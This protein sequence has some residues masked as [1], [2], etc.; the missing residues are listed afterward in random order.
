MDAGTFSALLNPALRAPPSPERPNLI[1]LPRN[2]QGWGL[3]FHPS[4]TLNTE[5]KLAQRR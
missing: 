4:R 5:G 3:C 1:P 2:G